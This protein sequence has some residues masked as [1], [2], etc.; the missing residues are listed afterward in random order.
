MMFVFVQDRV[1]PLAVSGTNR[2]TPKILRLQRRDTGYLGDYL[3]RLLEEHDGF[4]DLLIVRSQT[5]Q[6]F[7]F[8]LPGGRKPCEQGD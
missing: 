3:V 6:P 1:K 5:Q 2:D 8:C 7:D 4:F